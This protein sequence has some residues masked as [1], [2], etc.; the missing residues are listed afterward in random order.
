MSK[1]LTF[2]S[3]LLLLTLALVG[4]LNPLVFGV[5]I[6]LGILLILALI[7]YIFPQPYPGDIGKWFPKSNRPAQIIVGVIG[8]TVLVLTLVMIVS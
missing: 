4:W 6:P 8:L 5:L 2:A 1:I 3:G 7:P